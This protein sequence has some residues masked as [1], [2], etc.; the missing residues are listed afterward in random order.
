MADTPIVNLKMDTGDI[1][2]GIKAIET[3]LNNLGE[4]LN[5]SFNKTNEGLQKTVDYLTQQNT[6]LKNLTNAY[7]SFGRQQMAVSLQQTNAI[8]IQTRTLG[9]MI[10]GVTEAIAKQTAAMTQMHKQT[11][12]AYNEQN[13]SLVEIR[14]NIRGVSQAEEQANGRAQSNTRK[15][16]REMQKL[17]GVTELVKKGFDYLKWTLQRVFYFGAILKFQEALGNVVK[18]G[19]EFEK[20]VASLT[21]VTQGSRDLAMGAFQY[22]NDVADRIPFA[23]DEITKS[24]LILNKTGIKPTAE[25]LESLGAIAIGTGQSMF[26]Q[27]TAV[28]S[29]MTGNLRGLRMLGVEATFADKEHTKLSLTFNGETKVISKNTEELSRYIQELAKSS[30]Y[31]SVNATVMDGVTGK[32]QVLNNKWG[33]Y[34]RTLYLIGGDNMIK[35]WAD[36]AKRALDELI[37]GLKS[38]ETITAVQ[39]LGLAFDGIFD[40]VSKIPGKIMDGWTGAFRASNDQINEWGVNTE[41]VFGDTGSAIGNLG[42]LV[43]NVTKGLVAAVKIAGNAIAA[44]VV[45]T[46]NGIKVIVSATLGLIAE[47]LK[48]AV[49]GVKTAL[50]AVLAFVGT[51]YSRLPFMGD[52]VAASAQIALQKTTEVFG[53]YSQFFENMS[54][55][56][57]ITF[58]DS[59]K[60]IKFAGEQFVS[61]FGTIADQ[62]RGEQDRFDDELKKRVKE[63][64]ERLKKLQKQK[65]EYDKWLKSQTGNRPQTGDGEENGEEGAAGGA[66]RTAK[67]LKAEV[68]EAARAYERLR[69]EIEK[70][71]T[72]QLDA[73]DQENLKHQERMNGLKAALDSMVI[74]EQEYQVQVQTITEIHLAK[75]KE[76]YDKHYADLAK[77]RQEQRKKEEEFFKDFDTTSD[78]LKPVQAYLEKLEKHNIK[79]KDVLSGNLDYSKYSTKQIAA[80]YSSLTGA[81]SEYFGGLAQNF[82]ETSG[83]YKVFFAM[84]KGFAVASS[85]VSIWQGV[86]NAMAA[87]WPMNLVAWMEVLSQG[88][89]IIGNLQSVNFSGAKDRGGYIP[90]GSVGLVGEIG[91]ELVSGPAMVTSRRNTAELFSNMGGGA[92][93][94]V[95]LIEDASRAGQVEKEDTDEATIIQVCVANIH[96]GGELADAISNTYGVARQGV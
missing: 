57:G 3:G 24:A 14:N 92:S 67:R 63:S 44:A 68:D 52:K 50:S 31:A 59:L 12:Q 29:V 1:A 22:L 85:M 25:M 93:V 86:A 39:S 65:E 35:D 17:N 46:I 48:R 2:N 89:S 96:R 33:E 56:M 64:E 19:K 91:P 11:M 74:S 32:L 90:S 34:S 70:L 54:T 37:E 53:R 79:L 18:E 84:Q 72:A 30:R 94:V 76:M 20:T 43:F 23:F 4:K 38:H 7:M 21:A 40:A 47:L 80:L 10:R 81:V 61:D 13:K 51:A 8:H 78:A 28:S 15:T 26:T 82:D 73:I 5:Q 55:G 41:K 71:K 27:A 42:K 60:N 88:M 66:A 87:P 36:T 75:L 62:F 9:A 16:T 83:M 45:G 77:Q 69:Q 58:T 6:T 49:N 95:N